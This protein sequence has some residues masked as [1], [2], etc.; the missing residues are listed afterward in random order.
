MNRMPLE[1][2]LFDLDGTLVDTEVLYLEATARALSERGLS[3]PREELLNI[4]YGRSLGDVMISLRGRFPASPLDG[5]EERMTHHH[6]LLYRE[7]DV[8]IQSSVDLLRRLAA[9]YPVAVVSGSA[10]ADVVRYLSLLELDRCIRFHLGSEDY[11]PGKPDPACYF[12]AAERIGARPSRCLV[13]EDS[14]VGV[15]AAKSA[16]MTCVAL[17]RENTPK[18]DLESADLVLTDLDDFPA[19][20]WL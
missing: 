14:T 16:G 6:W 17:K 18:Q 11:S 7:N 19:D 12:L 15:I 9:R 20:L 1:A 13:F 5:L 3:V 2:F 8:V 10:R 4:V